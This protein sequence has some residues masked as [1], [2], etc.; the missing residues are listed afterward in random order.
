MQE[1]EDVTEG[2]VLDHSEASK[3][4]HLAATVTYLSM[5]RP[6][7]QFAASVLGRAMSRPTVQSVV[8]LTRVA[9]CLL[10]HSSMQFEYLRTSIE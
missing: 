9:R 1:A 6:D 5:D 10:K 7:V 3:Y 8:A 4:R 2:D